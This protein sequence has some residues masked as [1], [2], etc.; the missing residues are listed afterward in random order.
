MTYTPRFELPAVWIFVL[1]IDSRWFI[2]LKDNFKWHQNTG[3]WCLSASFIFAGILWSVSYF[4]KNW[5]WSLELLGFWNEPLIYIAVA[6]RV[7]AIHAEFKLNLQ[8][9][10]P[11]TVDFGCLHGSISQVLFWNFCLLLD[12][13]LLNSF[14]YI[15][16][17]SV[18]TLSTLPQKEV[19]K[20]WHKFT[21]TPL[22][23]LSKKVATRN[24]RI[25][26][27]IIYV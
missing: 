3:I 12:F 15:S 16:N 8:L 21:P 27:Q 2:R 7:H 17:N 9:W 18:V 4:G 25:L 20:E 14:S 22:T 10:S 24:K 6:N 11:C 13:F 19:R 23:P 1:F 5:C 26:Q